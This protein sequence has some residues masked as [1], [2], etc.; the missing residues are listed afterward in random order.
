[1]HQAIHQ[2]RRVYTRYEGY[3]PGRK[4]IHQVGRVSRQVVRVLHQVGRLHTLYKQGIT[5][6]R[7][8]T[9]PGRQVI[10][11]VGRVYIR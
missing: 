4:G 1:M 9:T 11:Q 6:G 3:A 10:H 7:Q 8:G 5:P 2:V